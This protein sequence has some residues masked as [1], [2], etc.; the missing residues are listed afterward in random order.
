MLIS[1]L[2]TNKLVDNNCNKKISR[3]ISSSNNTNYIKKP[4]KPFEFPW[5]MNSY[6]N[7]IPIYN[8]DYKKVLSILI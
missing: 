6:V 2:K 1:L 3:L 4:F 8:I 7:E 5:Y